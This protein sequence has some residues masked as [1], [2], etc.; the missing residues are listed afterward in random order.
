MALSGIDIS[1]WQ[2]GL[3]LCEVPCDFVVCKAT[4]GTRFVDTSCDKFIQ[5]ALTLRKL[6]GF[7]HFMD[8]SDPV[9]QAEYF[10]KNCQRY[11]GSGIPVLDYEAYGRIGTAGAKR[12]LDRVYELCGVRCMV[13]MSRSVC[14]E[15]DW[16]AIA[17]NH[18]LWVAQYA[19]NN[20]TGY[21]NQPW[22]ADG[23]FGAWSAPAIHQYSSNGRLDGY[24][25]ALDLD[26]AFM[27]AKAWERFANPSG[28]AHDTA[29]VSPDMPTSCVLELAAQVMRGE[30]GDGETRREALGARYDE[31]QGFIDHIASAS[32]QV[33]IDETKTGAYGNGDIRRAVLGSRYAEVQNAINGQRRSYTVVAGDTL[34]GIA[35]KLGCD[36]R[37]LADKNHIKRPYI[38]YPGQMLKY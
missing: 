22:L 18:A 37:T 38:I 35:A 25:S 34:S 26:I 21:Q 28:E 31:V 7:Y 12:F 1:N 30:F 13:Y 36:W 24:S 9:E 8:K 4:E 11:F 19:N 6:Y 16:S 3:N 2:A 29:A 27:D 15:E 17:P 5:Q 14:T 33:L 10:Y 32:I 23:G 20:P